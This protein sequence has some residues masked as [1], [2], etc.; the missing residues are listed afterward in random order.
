MDYCKCFGNHR[1]SVSCGKCKKEINIFDKDM[2]VQQ[3]QS[4]IRELIILN[5]Q[6]VKKL[7]DLSDTLI[8]ITK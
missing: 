8:E 6:V 2:R 7:A 3:L 5:N 4:D 1:L